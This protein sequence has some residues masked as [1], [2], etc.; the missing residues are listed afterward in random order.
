[1]QL[2]MTVNIRSSE[3]N[4]SLLEVLGEIGHARYHQEWNPVQKQMINP[5]QVDKQK[6]MHNEKNV[7]CSVYNS[8]VMC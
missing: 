1:M 4:I 8:T 5:A 6:R 3:Y 2:A 7:G